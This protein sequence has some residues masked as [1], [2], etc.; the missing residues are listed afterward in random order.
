MTRGLSSNGSPGSAGARK[1]EAMLELLIN[2]WLD[3]RISVPDG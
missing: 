3:S 1:G 2:L